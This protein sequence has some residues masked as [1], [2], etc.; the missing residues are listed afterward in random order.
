MSSASL[1]ETTLETSGKD[2]KN[3]LE[4]SGEDAKPKTKKKKIEVVNED[5]EQSEVEK[6]HSS[7]PLETGG[8][9]VC[10]KEVVKIVLKANKNAKSSKNEKHMV[11]LRKFTKVKN[12]LQ[13]G[14]ED[15]KLHSKLVEKL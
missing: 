12:T 3:T 9:D 15:V 1:G 13:T 7:S 6:P 10:V 5:S 8:E 4:T 11:R 14:G 2:A